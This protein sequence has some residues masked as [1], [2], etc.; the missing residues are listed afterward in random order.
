ME[1]LESVTWICTTI[2]HQ[3]HPR[4][5]PFLSATHETHPLSPSGASA[6]L[7]H[8]CRDDDQE[9]E[10]L[11]DEK[12]EDAVVEEQDDKVED[13]QVDAEEGEAMKEVLEVEKHKEERSRRTL[14][15]CRRI[16]RKKGRRRRW[17]QRG[18]DDD[19]DQ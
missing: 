18:K 16:T 15:W 1:I 2:A 19:E 7:S 17:R 10:Q 5:L 9:E 11:E 8:T 13:D 4:R 14:L 12:Q 3:E 6:I